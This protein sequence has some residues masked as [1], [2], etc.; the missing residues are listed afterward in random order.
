MSLSVS[1]SVFSAPHERELYTPILYSQKFQ[2]KTHFFTLKSLFWSPEAKN[3]TFKENVLLTFYPA[4]T[5]KQTHYFFSYDPPFSRGNHQ[6]TCKV[7]M[8]LY[9]LQNYF[10]MKRQERVAVGRRRRST[11][12]LPTA[13]RQHLFYTAGTNCIPKTQRCFSSTV[14]TSVKSTLKSNAH[15]APSLQ[16]ARVYT[17]CTFCT[18]PAVQESR[19]YTRIS[20]PHLTFTVIQQ[21]FTRKWYT[22][23]KNRWPIITGQTSIDSIHQIFCAAFW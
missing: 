18:Q 23:V 10:Q 2:K 11:P 15:R 21:M 8:S 5:Y 13:T 16:I 6:V 4:R 9:I 3:Q 19:V 12:P 7:A 20:K 17:C 22:T 1:V 14:S